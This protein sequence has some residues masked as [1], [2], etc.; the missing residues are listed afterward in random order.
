MLLP[1]PPIAQSSKRYVQPVRNQGHYVS[2]T[3]QPIRNIPVS[4]V[5][6]T[7]NVLSVFLITQIWVWIFRILRKLKAYFLQ[8]YVYQ[9]LI[10]KKYLN[11]MSVLTLVLQRLGGCHHLC[12]F[13]FTNVKFGGVLWVVV[14]VNGMWGI[15]KTSW[16][17]FFLKYLARYVTWYVD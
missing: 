8:S 2:I 1:P 15:G 5:A 7:C 6:N 16:F 4:I 9:K 3:M 10:F 13:F 12:D 17:L 14:K 11:N